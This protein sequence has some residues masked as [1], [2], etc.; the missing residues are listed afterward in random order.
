MFLIVGLG[1]PGRDYEHTRHNVGFDAIDKLAEKLDVNVSKI[2]FK[3]LYGE[4][5]FNGEKIILLKPST[6]MNL[7]GESLIEAASFFNIPEE[8]IIVIYDDVD[9]DVGRIRIRPSGSDGGHNGMKNIIYHLQSINFPRIRIGIG[10]PKKDMVNHVLGRF[11]KDEQEIMD[12]IID[13][14]A[15]AAIEIVKNGVQSSM[16]K[17]NP[18]NLSQKYE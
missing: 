10:K 7:S 17:Y 8:K 3:G 13:I 5:F 9:I 2:K 18:V 1:N 16:N 15:D 14:A 4:T 12:K 6:F 11:T